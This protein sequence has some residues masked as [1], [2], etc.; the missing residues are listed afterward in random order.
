MQ[1]AAHRGDKRRLI[2]HLVC[3]KRCTITDI[4]QIVEYSRSRTTAYT[5]HFLRFDTQ[6]VIDPTAINRQRIDTIE[7]A[8]AAIF[9]T[10]NAIFHS[11]IAIVYVASYDN[12]TALM[13]IIQYRFRRRAF[14]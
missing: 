7:A 1:Y 2:G 14:P 10:I 5:H 11:L 9:R 8:S 6:F 12:P 3:K 4:R 13:E